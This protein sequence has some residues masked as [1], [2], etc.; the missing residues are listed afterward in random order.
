LIL[1]D[2]GAESISEWVRDEVL[3]A[4]LQYRMSENLPTCYTSNFDYELLEQYLA[5][6]VKL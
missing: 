5:I 6:P 3:G 1:D 2:I 4:I